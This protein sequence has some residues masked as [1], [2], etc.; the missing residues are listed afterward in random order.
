MLQRLPG[1]INSH[2]TIRKAD[3]RLEKVDRDTQNVRPHDL[4]LLQFSGASSS[5]NGL[6]T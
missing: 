5:G 6:P 1:D 4:S 2:C 3:H